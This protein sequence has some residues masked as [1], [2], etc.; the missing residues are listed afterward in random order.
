M[1]AG[2]AGRS[3]HRRVDRVDELERRLDRPAR[4]ARDDCARDRAGV[5]LLAEVAQRSRQAPLVPVGDDLARTEL[6]RRVHPHVERRVVGVGE[7]A[8]A[9][10][11]LH[12]GHPEVEIRRVGSNSLLGEQRQRLGVSGVDEP[13]RAFD[14]GRERL[15]ALLCRR[16]AIDRDDRAAGADALGDESRV[17]AV[18]E[19]AVDHRLARLWVEQR[20]QLVGQ[21]GNVPA[22]C[23]RAGSAGARAGGRAAV[24][25]GR[26]PPAR[27]TSV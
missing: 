21:Y 5:A 10:V 23:A 11:D 16:V 24:R 6:L 15:E 2:E 13:K 26:R 20:Q 8:L 12:R 25:A 27:G 4:A 22:A 7:A 9:R 19:G 14:V 17:P 1:T 18:A 3:R